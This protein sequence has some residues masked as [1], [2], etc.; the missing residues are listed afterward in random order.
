MGCLVTPLGFSAPPSSNQLNSLWFKCLRWYFFFFEPLLFSFY[1]WKKL[2]DDLP[3]KKKEVT[4]PRLHVRN[5]QSLSPMILKPV[6]LT[7]VL[8]CHSLTN[9][10]KVWRLFYCMHAQLCPTLCD[11][12]NCSPPGSSV[13]G[14]NTGVG[15]NFLLQGIFTTQG[16]NLSLQC[17]LHWQVDSLSTEPLG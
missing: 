17:L 5:W 16:L 4:C 14:M 10:I 7:D 13:H 12:M 15:C 11:L 1:R 9:S 2:K 3:K 8:Y 6:L